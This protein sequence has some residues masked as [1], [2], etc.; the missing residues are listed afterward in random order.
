MT[1]RIVP[2]YILNIAANP[3]DG[4]I[5]SRALERASRIIVRARGSDYAKITLPKRNDRYKRILQGQI[6]IWTEIDLDG[7]WLDLDKGSEID[8]ELRE[9]ISIPPNARPNFRAFD[10]VFDEQK[11]QLYFEARNDLDQTVGATVVLRIFSG[12]LNRE[13]MGPDWPEIEVTLVP[14]HDAIERILALP[15][16]NTLM[17]RVGRPNPDAAS[18]EAV[19]RVNAKLEALHAQKLEIRLRKAAD[20]ARITLDPEFREIADVGA[21][22]GLVKGEGRY[23]DGSKAELSTRDQPRKIE[24]NM[25]KGDNFFARLISTIS[26]LV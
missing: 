8:P 6:L 18:P 22:N 7:P 2:V 25:A 5:Y 9:K 16:L 26:G 23:A 21:D 20:A 14:T 10:Y 15:H 13:L 3:H 1:D 24:I 19:A 11:H 17:I 4:D 12:I